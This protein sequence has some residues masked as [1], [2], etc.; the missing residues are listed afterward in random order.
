V[1]NTLII[2]VI[3]III[4]LVAVGFIA[5]QFYA[6]QKVA[7]SRPK[8]LIEKMASSGLGA[9]DTAPGV[10]SLID[11]SESGSEWG[12]GGSAGELPEEELFAEAMAST[13]Q[14]LKL[15]G[16]DLQTI[17]SEYLSAKNLNPFDVEPDFKLG[18]AYLKFAQYEKAQ[19]E[20]QKVIEAKPEFPGI[21]YYLGESFRCNGQFYEAMKAYKKSWEL[22][23]YD[24]KET[25]RNNA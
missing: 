1:I 13:G 9:L 7:A 4:L 18:V 11:R 8:T 12:S 20:F 24:S 17:Y 14:S 22:G 3:F 15:E 10:E 19:G 25:Q 21:Y 2:A 16:K 5:Q 23:M 6:V